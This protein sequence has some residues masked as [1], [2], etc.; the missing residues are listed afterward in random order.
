MIGTGRSR[1][2]GGAS[3]SDNAVVGLSDGSPGGGG[4]A[5]RSASIPTPSPSDGAGKST[6][7]VSASGSGDAPPRVQAGM[8]EWFRPSPSPEV[9]AGPAP[10]ESG[11]IVRDEPSPSVVAPGGGLPS[12]VFAGPILRPS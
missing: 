10:D 4:G 8:V 7:R 12:K 6:L 3:P 11:P 5:A 1:E 2:V 9:P